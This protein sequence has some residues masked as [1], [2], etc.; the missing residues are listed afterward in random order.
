MNI[1]VVLKYVGK[2]IWRL[3]EMKK[4][5]LFMYAIISLSTAQLF[6]QADNNGAKNDIKCDNSGYCT[7]EKKEE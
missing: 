3:L 7:I 5:F 4:L 1:I 6:L 2:N